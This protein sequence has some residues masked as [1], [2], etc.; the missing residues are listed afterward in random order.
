MN[1]E[2]QSFSLANELAPLFQDVRILSDSSFSLRDQVIAVPVEV[3]PPGTASPLTQQLSKFIY[4]RY[5]SKHIPD[6]DQHPAPADN[7]FLSELSQSNTGQDRLDSGWVVIGVG[8]GTLFAAAKDGRSRSFSLDQIVM[9]GNLAPALGTVVSVKL[10]R[11]ELKLQPTFY[12]ALGEVVSLT[13]DASAFLRLYFHISDYG[14]ARLISEVTSRLNRFRVPFQFKCSNRR[15][16]FTRADVAVLYLARRHYPFVRQILPE[17]YAAVEPCLLDT[18][19]LLTKRL[20]KGLALAE[21]LGN[22]NSFGLNRS[23]LLAQAFWNSYKK[24]CLDTDSLLTEV[25][26]VFADA[27]VSPETPYLSAG[28]I[29]NYALPDFY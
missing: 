16:Q 24:K 5:Y 9:P 20:A 15:Q 25:N 2:T 12:I 7:A 23:Q 27:G 28:S 21:D 18:T 4:E 8:D 3:G 29:D 19:P 10:V 13:S 14:A 22:G 11:E 17:I 1:S 6:T 26:A